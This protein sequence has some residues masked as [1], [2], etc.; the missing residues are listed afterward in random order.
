[1][2]TNSASQGAEMMKVPNAIELRFDSGTLVLDGASQSDPTLRESS[3]FRWDERT[4][5]CRDPAYLYR[6]AVTTLV[7]QDIPYQDSARNYFEFQFRSK[8]ELAPRPY[9]QE[10]IA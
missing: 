8:R 2:K 1:M 9:Q 10:A 7:R 3:V 4:R 5:Q 6:Q